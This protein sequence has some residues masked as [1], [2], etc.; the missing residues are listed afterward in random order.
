MSATV[1]DVHAAVDAGAL[2]YERLVQLYLRRVEAYDRNGPRLRAV[3]EINPRAAETARALDEERRTRG[4]R[5][6]LHGIPIAVKDNVDVRDLPSTGGSVIFAGNVPA[7]DAT[8]VRKLRDAGAIVLLKTN[9][10]EL[11]L[12]SQ[13]FSSLGGQTLN[14]YDLTRNPGGSSGG[15]A[16][17]VTAAFATLGIATETGISIRG[18]AS[19]CSLVGIAP[20]RGLVSRAGAIPISYT[21]DR[22]G[23][24]AKSV[25]DAT[26]LLACIKGFDPDDLSTA[27]S[28]GQTMSLDAVGETGLRGRRM[29]VLRDLFRQGDEFAEGNAV[30][31]SRLKVLAAEGAVLVDDLS[32]GEDLVGLMP[33][34]RVNNYELQT[35]F[36]AYLHRRGP[37]RPVTSLKELIATGKYVATLTTRFKE[38]MEAGDPERNQEYLRRLGVQRRLQAAL[39]AT[40]DRHQVEAVVYPVKSL[41]APVIGEPDSGSRDNAISSTTGLPAV[42]L[43][44]GTTNT[45]LPLALELL[46]R[47]FSDATLLQLAYGL[48][49]ADNARVTPATTPSLDGESFTY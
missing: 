23:V 46:G 36:D 6:P 31:E 21:Q 3:I 35:T 1:A 29:G 22:I 34:L 16:V 42:V 49:Q 17:A 8:V 44:A 40:M 12:N 48:Q 33:A 2:T 41:G 26:H 45:G 38:T 4:R 19:N 37:T 13:G 32:T 27:A 30:V 20:S 5:G 47:P 10:D 39:V 24:H 18:P 25:M 9:M 11:A 7:Y 43:P 15:T 14:P 28:L